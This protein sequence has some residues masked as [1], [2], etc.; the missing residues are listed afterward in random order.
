LNA[1]DQQEFFRIINVN[2]NSSKLNQ[3][4]INIA[5]EPD[6][7][8]LSLRIADANNPGNTTLYVPFS[9]TGFGTFSIDMTTIS[10]ALIST[11][12]GVRTISIAQECRKICSDP[13]EANIDLVIT[14]GNCGTIVDPNVVGAQ[15]TINAIKEGFTNI[16]YESSQLHQG[17]I[18]NSSVPP[19]DGIYYYDIAFD[20]SNNLA[21]WLEEIIIPINTQFFN[22]NSVSIGNGITFSAPLSLPNANISLLNPSSNNSTL[23]IDIG[24]IFS[25]T[26]PGW[27]GFNF[28]YNPATTPQGAYTPGPWINTIQPPP[29]STT[30]LVVRLELSSNF[31]NQVNCPDESIRLTPPNENIEFTIKNS[32]GDEINPSYEPNSIA[33]PQ[34]QGLP[35]SGLFTGPTNVNTAG[36]PY[37]FLSQI[38]IPNHDPFQVDI[39]STGVNTSLISTPIECTSIQYRVFLSAIDLSNNGV[40]TSIGNIS[41]LLINGA[42]ASSNSISANLISF[43]LTVPTGG[44][45]P[46]TNFSIEF[47][48]S[49]MPCPL[50]SGQGQLRYELKIVAICNDC[51]QS[52]SI[53]SNSIRNLFCLSTDVI[54][55]CNGQ[56]PSPIETYDDLVVE[57]TTFGWASLA[58]YNN[59]LA[60]LPDATAFTSFCNNQNIPNQPTVITQNQIYDQ[61]GRLYPYDLFK[62]SVTGKID[63]VNP[64]LHNNLSFEINYNPNPLVAIPPNTFF[65]IENYRLKFTPTNG[66]QFITIDGDRYKI[67]PG[68]QVAKGE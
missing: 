57:R 38:S 46:F 29:N 5:N 3:F 1:F 19:C 21:S 34:L 65:T 49:G 60:P 61:L 36:G 45:Q 67:L 59:G 15:I 40:N 7:T 43:D 50:S 9:P 68:G 35:A 6:V 2:I 44:N 51:N 8:E 14:C 23:T 47:G 54:V 32:C 55:H 64:Y 41:N 52:P 25:L 11:S 27:P 53:P 30:D 33:A 28:A 17:N 22:V 58:D 20:Y 31:P 42:Q 13:I 26:N 18:T 39:N 4:T 56:C 16:E 12:A 66:G 24:S 10:P 63:P 37:F 48:V 62:L